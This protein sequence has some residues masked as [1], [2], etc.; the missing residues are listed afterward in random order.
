MRVLLEHFPDPAP[1]GSPYTFAIKPHQRESA[2]MDRSL[3]SLVYFAEASASHADPRPE[4]G[5]TRALAVR[6]ADHPR[7]AA[8]PGSPR[9]RRSAQTLRPR[10]RPSLPPV[11]FDHGRNGHRDCRPDD[12][13]GQPGAAKQGPVAPRFQHQSHCATRRAGWCDAGRIRHPG[14]S[15]SLMASRPP[16]DEAHK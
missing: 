7:W 9:R 10:P 15:R 12:L 11:R 1:T 16:L 13:S 3:L 8:V 14:C 5:G 4:P 2:V 6:C